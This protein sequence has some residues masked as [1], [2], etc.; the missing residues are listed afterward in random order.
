MKV[1]QRQASRST[2]SPMRQDQA[3]LLGELDELAGRHQAALR[4][5]PA[6]QRL[7][8]RD[9]ARSRASTIGW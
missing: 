3:G 4:V 6:Q 1:V 9:R 8:R 2:H 7:V 5:L